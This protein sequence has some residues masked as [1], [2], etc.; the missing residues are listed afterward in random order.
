MTDCTWGHDSWLIQMP[1]TSIILCNITPWEQQ[2]AVNDI[3]GFWVWDAAKL[4]KL[5]LLSVSLT[6]QKSNKFYKVVELE[7][8]IGNTKPQIRTY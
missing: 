3:L 8:I 7:T 2:K 5:L 1:H 4:W 6:N